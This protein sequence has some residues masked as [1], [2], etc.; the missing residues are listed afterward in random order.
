MTRCITCTRCIRF[1]EEYCGTPVLGT[2]GRGISTE[3]GTYVE[4]L[5]TSELSGNLVDLCPVGA[6][7]NA[8]Y[9]FTARPWELRRVQSHDVLDP[10][11]PA[12]TVNNKGAELMRVLPRV[13]EE[14]NEEWIHDR[15]RHAF[16]GLKRQRLSE[17]L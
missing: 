9:A 8:P 10:M 2:T 5:L 11:G 12:I 7:T 4:Q 3:V 17:C 15:S 6:L 1:A 13:H 16:D 14:I